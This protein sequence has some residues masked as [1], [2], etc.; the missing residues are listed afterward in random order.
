M[1]VITITYVMNVD[2]AFGCGKT[3][4]RIAP[5]ALLERVQ[6]LI[7]RAVLVRAQVNH[8]GRS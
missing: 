8:R 3:S 2:L 7:P 5:I 6:V 4:R 1:M